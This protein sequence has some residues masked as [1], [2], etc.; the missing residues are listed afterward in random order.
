ML[1]FELTLYVIGAL[2]VLLAIVQ[3]V[4]VWCWCG[5]FWKAANSMVGLATAIVQWE[6]ALFNKTRQHRSPVTRWI[7]QGYTQ[8]KAHD[9]DSPSG[10]E[11]E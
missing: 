1:G 10:E 4:A 8:F 2:A 5:P 6:V 7:L 9:S 3:Y 11:S